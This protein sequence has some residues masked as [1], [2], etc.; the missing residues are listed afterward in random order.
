M[1]VDQVEPKAAPT[2]PTRTVSVPEALQIAVEHH[3][4]GQLALAETIYRQILGVEANHSDALHLL[5][6]IAYQV[7]QYEL[8]IEYINQAVALSLP[9]PLF[10][11]NLGNSYKALGQPEQAISSYLEALHT[12][13]NFDVAA[14]SLGV[15]F[16]E[17]GD[18]AEAIIN[19]S[20][21][22]TL[23]PAYAAAHYNLGCTL[24]ELGQLEEALASYSKS[25]SIDPCLADAHYNMAAI[26]QH[27]GRLQEAEASYGKAIMFKENFL[28]AYSN[29]GFVLKDQGKLNEA[30][31][32]YHKLLSFK[33]DAA[34]V[35]NNLG[36]VLQEQGK[37]DEATVNY[38]RALLI[39]P[40]FAEAHYNLGGTLQHQFKWEEAIASY[41][42]A[43]SFKP[44]YADAH[45]SLGHLLQELCEQDKA[46]LSYHR[47][48]SINPDYAEAR[49]AL[50]MS[51]LPS[52]YSEGQ[53]PRAYRGAF[54]RQ[55]NELDDWFVSGRIDDGFKAV[56]N[57]PFYLA[58]QEEDNLPL[59]SSYGALCH[60]L[61]QHWQ[62][63]QVYQ[64]ATTAA[65][66]RIKIGIVSH[67][68][69][70]HSVWHALVKGWLRHLDQNRFELHVIYLGSTQD[71]ET[72]LAQSL[73]PVFIMGK[74][75]LAMWAEAILA[76]HL[77][78]LIYPEI[79]MD[80]MTAKLANL[81]L[82]PLQIA[83]WGHPETT[84]LPTIDYFLS[85]DDFEP[86]DAQS[87][88]MESLVKLPHLGCCYAESDS[89]L[90]DP[91]LDWLG[92]KGDSPLLL[93]PGAP[94]K[95]APQHD[96]VFPEIARCLGRCNLLFFT[97]SVRK[98][99]EALQ[100]RLKTAFSS[101]GLNYD[102]YVTFIPWQP[103]PVF[104]G[105]MKRA[106]VYLDTIGFSGFNTAMQAVEC[107]LP[108]VTREGRF[109]RGRFAS[110]ILKRMGLSEL[111]AVSEDD[112]IVSA[113]RLVRD[114]KY[115]QSIVERMMQSRHTLFDDCI[116]IRALEEFLVVQCRSIPS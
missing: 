109:M 58:Y 45:Y 99:S 17:Q 57:S 116:P 27:Q 13:P 3:Q 36:I 50:T 103:R 88:Y 105:L 41:R 101:A 59:L 23:N 40:S 19:Y 53:D 62:Q 75:S 31:G 87:H 14:F 97:H 110:G 74:R 10:L 64:S 80:P 112:Y 47:A 91:C 111:I 15:V 60:R 93:C 73:V 8:S 107:G 55:L 33:P 95:Y 63:N 11:C 43:L 18:H 4:T 65:N 106:D 113:V 77:E 35:Y 90:D 1:R 114:K 115:R 71:S 51:Q 24:D 30:V 22:I 39:N 6:V 102:D 16:T 72:A 7:G 76:Q 61:M 44:D 2:Q 79:G 94:F 86:D 48:L 42:Q 21:A 84:A 92:I 49:W 89:V 67:H 5:G 98:M 81:R 100:Q 83:A 78:I 37:F 32:C 46:I 69:H 38:H 108:I 28:K 52:I 56:G 26:F 104:Y 34:D 12:D 96:W 85:A 29:L 66:G 82:A 68:V 54:L 25:V 9:N 20:R 70:D